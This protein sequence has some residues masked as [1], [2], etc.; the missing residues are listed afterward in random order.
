MKYQFIDRER[1][2]Y[3]VVIQCKVLEVHRSGYYAW[4]R[5]QRL[6]LIGK[7]AQ[8]TR[9][10]R[11]AIQTV[12]RESGERYGAPRIT[13]VLRQRGYRCSRGRVARTMRAQRIKAKQ[14]R[15]YRVTTHSNHWL[16]SPNLLERRFGMADRVNQ[17]W[18]SDIT[19]VSTRQG[20]LY[21]AIVLDLYSR[22]VVGL[23]MGNMLTKGLV[24]DALHQ[25]IL[26]RRPASGLLLH[27]DRGTQY[28]SSQYRAIIREHHMQQSMSRKGDCWDNAP[29]ESFFKTLKVEE[30]YHRSYETRAEA[31]QSIFQY[32][33]IFYN[34]RRV[35]STL[36]Y[37][38]PVNFEAL[39][40]QHIGSN[41]ESHS[42][43]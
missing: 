29:T 43:S 18:T 10:L 22:K 40:H 7:R 13:A 20:W 36:N 34:R 38:S 25:A 16:A 5:A 32:I 26:Q 19:Y 2:H 28:S 11:E 27:S 9:T 3:P 4:S 23:A 24:C 17:I 41:A 8:E 35:H 42:T 30:V 12:H 21:V 31:A 14:Y 1:V 33:E 15:A 39:T 6:Q 37:Q